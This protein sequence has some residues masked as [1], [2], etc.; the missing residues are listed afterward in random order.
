MMTIVDVARLAGV[1]TATVSRVINNPASVSVNTATIVREAM[2]QADYV[3]PPPERRRG[4]R[5]NGKPVPER[6]LKVDLLALLVPEITGGYYPSLQA[7][8]CSAASQAQ[9]QVLVLNSD[10]NVHVQ[11]DAVIQLVDNSVS[12]LVMVPVT[13]PATPLHQVRMLQSHG[14][15]VVFCHRRPEGA[16]A[17]LFGIPFEEVGYRAGRALV[18]AGHRR[19]AFVGQHTQSVVR[20]HEQ[21]FRR[22]MDEAGVPAGDALFIYGPS[23]TQAPSEQHLRECLENMMAM[24]RGRRPTAIYATFDTQAER[25]YLLLSQMGVRIPEEMSL[26]GFGDVRRQGA[27]VERLTSVVVDETQAGVD[28]GNLLCEMK[29]G[30]RPLD[31]DECFSL[32]VSVCAGRTVGP[33]VS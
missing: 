10:N 23:R 6:S 13:Y 3:P 30:V 9:H 28:A 17:P 26:I 33:P 8:F 12:G 25:I 21:G 4:R 2:K 29:R 19:L 14:I 31:L 18:E 7:G 5:G 24:P 27:I 16:K 32:G 20:R 11:A 15:P 22:A 1:S